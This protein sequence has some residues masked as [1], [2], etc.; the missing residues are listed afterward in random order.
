ML[1]FLR[2]L[3]YI[4]AGA[5]LLVNIEPYI[6][7]T[8]LVF[9][10]AAGGGVCG[11]LRYFPF[12]GGMA[13]WVCDL[14]AAAIYSLGGVIVWATFQTIELLPIAANFYIPFLS[15]Y[16]TKLE[17]APQALPTPEDR[18]SVK[19]VKKKLNTY[20]E[21]SLSTLLA[22]SWIMYIAD[23]AL[24]CWLYSPLNRLSE[25]QPIALIRTLLGVFGVELVIMGITLINNILDPSTIKHP[26]AVQREGREVGTS[27]GTDIAKQ[28]EY[29][30]RS[31]S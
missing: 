11:Q 30:P 14:I 7:V 26:K 9:P 18:E 20:V 10:D 13:G 28:Y 27:K 19:K 22:V 2:I 21:R 16:L 3:L 24:M 15:N 23:L 8:K 29:S 4:G 1:K 25:L 12:L 6:A 17:T 31:G 5:L